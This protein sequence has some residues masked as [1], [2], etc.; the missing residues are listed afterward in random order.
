[1][2]N[3]RRRNNADQ[4]GET[5]G[6]FRSG[7][8]A[9]TAIVTGPKVPQRGLPWAEVDGQAIFEGDIVL[10]SAADL[11]AAQG[12]MEEGRAASVGITGQSFR[13]PSGRIPYEIDPGMPNQQRVT[14]A[15]AHWHAHTSIRFVPKGAADTN[16]VR[17]VGGSGCSS[18]VGMRGGRQD[19]TLG[20]GCSAGNAI[21]EI[22]HTVGLWHEQSREDRDSFITINWA[23]I[24]PSTQ[25]NFTQ[26]IQDGDD[27]GAYD[28]GSI[29]H[30]PPDA[31][32]INGQPT[33]VPRQALPAGVVMG[34]RT[35]LSAGD[36]AGVRAMYPSTKPIKDTV[37]D[38]PKDPIKD[39]RK[40]GIKDGRKDP[41]KDIRKEPLKEGIKDIRKDPIKDLRKDGVK[42]PIRDTI[43][44]IRKDPIR[45]TIKEIRKDPIKDFRKEPVKDPILDPVKGPAADPI[46][47]PVGPI[48]PVVNPVLP[49]QDAGLGMT[50]FVLATP[51]RVPD[52]GQL[53]MD[54]GMGGYDQQLS[55]YDMAVQQLQDLE[56]MLAEAEAHYAQVLEAYEAAMQTVQA[57]GQG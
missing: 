37:K 40:D 48:G 4:P 29:M 8:L 43:K 25:H 56:Q 21:H 42:D 11:A 41:I 15:I 57:L 22:G 6:E 45:D 14:D 46:G 23:N 28:Y 7:P 19:I 24:D 2:T 18:M 34:Q 3:S 16:Y 35:G 39:L 5:R 54:A 49:G 53:G 10:G 47:P 30:Y 44:E 27:L 12:D 52:Y 38:G 20:N 17:F 50:P 36:I 9:G 31:F 1:M 26:H 33:I 55:D 51:S 32:S 13:W